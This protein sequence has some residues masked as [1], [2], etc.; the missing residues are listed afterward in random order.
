MSTILEYVYLGRDNSIDILLK[1]DGV[2]VDLS[3]VTQ[4]DLIVGDVTISST[5]QGVD[6]IRWAQVGYD[7]GEVRLALGDSSITASG[8]Q[9]AYLIVYDP[10]NTAGINWGAIDLYVSTI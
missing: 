4:I 8:K 1:A 5:N 6:L 10:T 7:T 9:R 2:A 3:S